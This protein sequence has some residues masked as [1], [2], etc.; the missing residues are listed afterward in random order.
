VTALVQQKIRA[1]LPQGANGRLHAANLTPWPT[2]VRLTSREEHL[3]S[4]LTSRVTD[5]IV[6]RPRQSARVTSNGEAGRLRSS[7]SCQA[8]LRNIR[9]REKNQPLVSLPS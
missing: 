7:T 8:S 5:R 2:A 3:L 6:E 4:E 9:V 1:S